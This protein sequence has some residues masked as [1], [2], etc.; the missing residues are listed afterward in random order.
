MEHKLNKRLKDEQKIKKFELTSLEYDKKKMIY[1]DKKIKKD[2]N[3][4]K[5]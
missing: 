5:D 4:E 2:G 3:I 1:Q